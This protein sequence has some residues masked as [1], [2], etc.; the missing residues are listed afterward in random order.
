MS[1]FAE[2]VPGMD[3]FTVELGDLAMSYD[4]YVGGDG[5]P[6]IL[7][8]EIDG[9]ARQP[10]IDLCDSLAQRGFKVYAPRFFDNMRQ[11]I[12][13]CMRR[14]FV[15]WALGQTSPIT[16]WLAGLAAEIERRDTPVGGVGIIGMCFSGG[17]AMATLAG[18]G[19]VKA[20][21]AAQPAMPWASPAVLF[22]RRRERA[23]G[24]SPADLARLGHRLRDGTVRVLP[25]RFLRDRVCP[26]AR[27]EAIAEIE[28]ADEVYYVEG[29]GHPTLT[30]QFRKGHGHRGSQAAIEFAAAWLAEILAEPIPPG[31]TDD[32]GRA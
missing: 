29:R 21:V 23:L 13:V 28:G 14:E 32:D 30:L 7:M 24:M 17:L 16:V 8:H 3:P 9:M 20:A 1:A 18:E 15:C 27:V 10:F 6:L 12:M 19:P 5:L 11:G 2:P 25:M 22:P 4:V 26:R 31:A